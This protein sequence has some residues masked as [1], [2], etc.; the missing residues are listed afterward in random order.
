QRVVKGDVPRREAA[1]RVVVVVQSQAD[2]LQVVLALGPVG[3]LTHLLD[4]RQ[5]QADE[6]SNDGDDDE[7]FNERESVTPESGHDA[8]PS[9]RGGRGNV[10][11][12]GDTTTP[13]SY[14][15]PGGMQAFHYGT[16]AP[17]IR[18]SRC[19]AASAGPHW[20]RASTLSASSS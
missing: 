6:Y 9:R 19:S 16:G 4:G 15:S 18:R 14:R 1:L 8:P 20:R 17:R 10:R 13:A 7:Q 5:Q 3:R 12:V 2:L 11:V